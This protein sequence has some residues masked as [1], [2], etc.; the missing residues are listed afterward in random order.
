[1][2]VHRRPVI[3]LLAALI[4]A[5]GC[6][7]GCTSCSP[8][9][10]AEDPLALMPADSAVL[11]EVNVAAL[12]NDAV[13]RLLV[14]EVWEEGCIADTLLTDVE[15]ITFSMVDAVPDER[16]LPRIAVRIRDAAPREVMECLG[17]AM[18]GEGV[19]AQ[20][21]EYRG[22]RTWTSPRMG[23]LHVGV[24][25]D[26][27]LV[28]GDRDGVRA[29][30]DTFL[31]GGP[32]VAGEQTFADLRGELPEGAQVRLMA[33][34]GPVLRDVVI[35]RLDVPWSSVLDAGELVAGLRFDDSEL[36]LSA[37]SSTRA[38]PLRLARITNETLDRSRKNRIMALLGVA[39][40]LEDL[41]V[42]A[43][44]AYLLV[45]GRA[46]GED[47]T[48]VIEGASKFVEVGL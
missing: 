21:G 44:G 45:E 36:R 2:R 30:V 26:R 22:V 9:G 37:R 39:D 34:P 12:S 31:D 20:E 25:N 48:D 6:S 8:L 17:G 13:F 40:L 15:S 32:S 47:V 27:M 16:T 46:S 18:L 41:H 7:R 38:D 43:T 24:V 10:K 23:A 4:A 28:A 42:R 1:M 5:G 35:A 29:M 14:M 3:V 19:E 11:V 33:R